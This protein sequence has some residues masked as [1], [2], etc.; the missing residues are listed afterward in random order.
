MR[1]D[2]LTRHD[3]GMVGLLG[4]GASCLRV[5]S[6]PGRDRRTALSVAPI[7]STTDGGADGLCHCEV[8]AFE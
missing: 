6:D 4:C 2:D 7:G 3:R 1:R 8:G 5:E